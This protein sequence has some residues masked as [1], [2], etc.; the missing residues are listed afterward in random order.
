MKYIAAII[1]S[2]FAIFFSPNDTAEEAIAAIKQG[3]VSDLIKLFDEKVSIKLI[4]QEDVLSKAQ[5][6][7]NIKVFFEKH[8]VKNFTN[9][10]VSSTNANFQYL[11]GNLE[12]SNGKYRVSILIRRGLISQFR[13]ETDNE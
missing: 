13:I 6:E 2:V 11:T 10:H 5:A 12:T 7:A 9:T 3:K 4:N 8:P 1:I